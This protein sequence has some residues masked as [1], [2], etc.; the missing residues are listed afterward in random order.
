MYLD[1]MALRHSKEN[2]MK[3]KMLLSPEETCE[4]LGI[5]RSTLFKMLEEGRIP[6]IKI[7]RLR[8]IPVEGIRSWVQQ[9][10][11]EQTGA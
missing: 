10:I 7:G 11:E 6:S 1:G 4:V 9:Q 8:R 5:K 3:N 2:R